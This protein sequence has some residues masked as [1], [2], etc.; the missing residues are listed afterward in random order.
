MNELA[1]L[2]RKNDAP[3]G[4]PLSAGVRSHAPGELLQQLYGLSERL[5][6]TAEREVLRVY[7][8]DMR[9]WLVLRTL[10]GLEGAT[11]RRIAAATDLDKV[12]VNRAAAWLKQR[13]LITSV[14]NA[15]DGR[16]HFLA[17][18]PK[19]ADLLARC[20]REVAALEADV[21]F[22]LVED[23]GTELSRLLEHLQRALARRA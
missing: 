23:D 22:G 4:A 6:M 15:R 9:D 2:D 17:L 13:G 5:R 20:L 8:L 18:S 10:D 12:A 21:M 1:L 11:Q 3:V 19:G 14:P 16:S 7:Q